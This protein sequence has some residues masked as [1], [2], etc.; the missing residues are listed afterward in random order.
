[1][2]K[3]SWNISRIFSC[4]FS[5]Y[6]WNYPSLNTSIYLCFISLGLD[7]D[8]RMLQH[9]ETK[10]KGE[11]TEEQRLRFKTLHKNFN[12]IDSINLHKIFE[13]E[14]PAYKNFH[15]IFADLGYNTYNIKLSTENW[16]ILHITIALWSIFAANVLMEKYWYLFLFLQSPFRPSRMGVLLS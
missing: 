10:V 9:V 14:F 8:P 5:C 6:F 13:D 1:M 4:I 3:T 7:M 11:L 12:S 2:R 15:A 16:C